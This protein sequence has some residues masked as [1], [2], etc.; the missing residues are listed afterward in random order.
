MINRRRRSK[1]GKGGTFDPQNGTLVEHHK[2]GVWDFY[3]ERDAKLSYFPASWKIEEYAGIFNDLPYLWRTIRDVGAVAWPLLLLYL[4]ISLITSLI[5]ALNLW[6]VECFCLSFMKTRL[7]FRFS[8]QLLNIVSANHAKFPQ[9][10]GA[11]LFPSR[12]A[13]SVCR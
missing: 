8:G 3:V 5:P 6:C 13:G 10:L 11:E 2:L 1:K 9:I 12:N 7:H 4:A